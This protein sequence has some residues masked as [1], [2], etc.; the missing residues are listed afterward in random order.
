M[1]VKLSRKQQNRTK[2]HFQQETVVPCVIKRISAL[3]RI[4]IAGAVGRAAGAV[5]RAVEFASLEQWVE[6]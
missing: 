6:R 1:R 2:N 5:G 4:R 3:A